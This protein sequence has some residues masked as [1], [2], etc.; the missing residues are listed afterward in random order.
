MWQEHQVMYRW[1]QLHLS[2]FDTGVE[3]VLTPHLT[4]PALYT[5]Q[6]L[7]PMGAHSVSGWALRNITGCHPKSPWGIEGMFPS[8]S[9]STIYKMRVTCVRVPDFLSYLCTSGVRFG[10]I[11]NPVQSEVQC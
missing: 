7:S 9:S 8:A 2:C 4:E 11:S 3:D 6:V 5:E 1:L 10:H